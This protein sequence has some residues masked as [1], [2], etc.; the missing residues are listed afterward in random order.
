MQ[1]LRA[2]QAAAAVVSLTCLILTPAI[3]GADRGKAVYIGGTLSGVKEKSEAPID[4]KGEEH[5]VFSPKG[6]VAVHIPWSGIEEVEYGQKAGHR[7]K[8]AIF[9]TPLALFSKNRRH[10]VTLAWKDAAGKAQAAVFEFDKDDIRPALAS[11]RA[12]SGKEIVYQDEQA[13]KQ[14]GAATEK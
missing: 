3:W 7:V 11:I 13:K 6:A 4:L 12:R 14:M 9:L 5:L 8:T 2:I 1:R 10:Y